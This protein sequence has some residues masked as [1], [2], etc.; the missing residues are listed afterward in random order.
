[1]VENEGVSASLREHESP[2]HCSLRLNLQSESNGNEGSEKKRLKV[3]SQKGKDLKSSARKE[4][5]WQKFLED[6]RNDSKFLKEWQKK[7]EAVN[8]HNPVFTCFRSMAQTVMQ[9]PPN[10]ISKTRVK[11][12]QLV[13]EME[14]KPLYEQNRPTALGCPYHNFSLSFHY[15]VLVTPVVVMSHQ[16]PVSCLLKCC[17]LQAQQLILVVMCHHQNQHQCQHHLKMEMKEET[18]HVMN[19]ILTPPA[20][21]KY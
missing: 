19:L 20:L 5:F 4:N 3:I 2:D 17:H 8:S 12:C 6:V 21:L 1:V 15:Q 11:V 10:I 7:I 16:H 18:L 13:G 14:A 9:F